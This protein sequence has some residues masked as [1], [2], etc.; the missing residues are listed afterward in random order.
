MELEQTILATFYLNPE[1]MSTYPMEAKWLQGGYDKYY[2]WMLEQYLQAPSEPIVINL[3]PYPPG[4]VI[5]NLSLS[6]PNRIEEVIQKVREKYLQARF[7]DVAA[8]SLQN[9]KLP[10]PDKWISNSIESLQKLQESNTDEGSDHVSLQTEF[11]ME[12]IAQRM[13]IHEN[14]QTVGIST[15]NAPLDASIGGFELKENV[16]L[17]G[18]PGMGKTT[19]AINFCIAAARAGHT[20]DFYSLEMDKNKILIKIYCQITGLHLKDVYKGIISDQD[21]IKIQHAADEVGELPIFIHDNCLS[22]SQI[23]MNARKINNAWDTKLL[24]IDYLQLIGGDTTVQNREQEVSKVSREI[25]LLGM[26]MNCVTM[27]LCQLNRSVE[28]RA[29]KI[30]LISDLRESGSIEQDA[31]VIIFPYRPSYYCKYDEVPPHEG[32]EFIIAKNRMGDTDHVFPADYVEDDTYLD[33]SYNRV[34]AHVRD[35]FKN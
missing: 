17:A 3:C 20:V 22:W 5:E 8:K 18:R 30:P 16:I 11:T 2:S 15:G 13:D 21:Y 35:M 10:D 25:K 6:A 32:T 24:A 12:F 33:P 14:G 9:A 19:E 31:D 1:L 23:K 27:P 4:Y 34:P 26:E 29:S 28:N 7:T